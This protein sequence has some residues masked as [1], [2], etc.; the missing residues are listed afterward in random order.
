MLL[1]RLESVVLDVPVVS[2]L[3]PRPGAILVP[4][5]K[6]GRSEIEVV[7]G[8]LEPKSVAADLEGTG[9]ECV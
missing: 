9:S 1:R 3:R 5:S 2:L 4:V 6:D 8:S 7:V